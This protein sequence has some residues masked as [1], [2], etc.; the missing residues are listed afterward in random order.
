MPW[1]DSSYGK[2]LCRNEL[3]PYSGKVALVKGNVCLYRRNRA[4]LLCRKGLGRAPRKES[5][6]K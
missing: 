4:K 5:P 6:G 1:E 2:A 3:R